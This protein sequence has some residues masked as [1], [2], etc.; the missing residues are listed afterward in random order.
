MN[1]NS[2]IRIFVDAHVVDGPHQGTRTFIEQ[3]YSELVHKPGIRIFIAARNTAELK[4]VFENN[5]NVVYVKYRSNNRMHRLLVEIP[6]L[7]KKHKIDYAHFQYITPLKTKC[8]TIV[9]THDV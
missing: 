5:E 7:L 3:L 6:Y 1:G 9:T 8:K 4:R 2:N